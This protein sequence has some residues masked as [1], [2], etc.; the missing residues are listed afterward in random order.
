MVETILVDD[1]TIEGFEDDSE[2]PGEGFGITAI[3]RLKHADLYRAAKKMGSQSALARHLE[4]SPMEIGRWI[5]MKGCPPSRPVG[6]RWTEEY[7]AIMGGKLALLTGKDWDELFPSELRNNVEFLRCSKT[8]ERTRDIEQYALCD[9]A[10]HTQRRLE[11]NATAEKEETDQEVRDAI[12]SVLKTLTYRER[13]I[14]RL[15]YGLGDGCNYTLEETGRIFKV[16]RER[17][18]QIESKALRKLQHDRRFDILKKSIDPDSEW[19]HYMERV[20]REK[21]TADARV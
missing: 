17:I 2:S 6:K 16:P 1:P 8:V 14:I 11:D 19:G 9:Y 15:R 4:I 18:R 5:N 12:E 7:L 13:E 21:E 10:V 3:T 20:E